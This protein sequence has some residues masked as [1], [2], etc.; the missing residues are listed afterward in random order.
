MIR[1]GDRNY[2]YWD[3]PRTGRPRSLKCPDDLATAKRRARALNGLLDEHRVLL[4]DTRPRQTT[5]LAQW[6]AVWE[7]KEKADPRPSLDDR[8]RKSRR[9]LL[10]LGEYGAQPLEDFPTRALSQVIESEVA[11]GR[12]RTAKVYRTVARSWFRRAL[13][14][15]LFPE[16]RANPADLLDAIKDPVT[17]ARLT[18]EQ[19]RA[20]RAV[21]ASVRPWLGD[22]MDL[23]LVTGQRPADL[24]ALRFADARDGYLWIKQKKTDSRVKI[25]ISLRLVAADLTVG[26][27]VAQCRNRVLSPH[28]LHHTASHSGTPAGAPLQVLN[29]ARAF[30]EA[31]TMAEIGGEHPPSFY[32][33]RSLAARLY[34]E[35]GVD[36]QV[37]LGHKHASMTEVYTDRRGAEW[38]EVTG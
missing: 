19:W 30:R 3:D 34:A 29:M 36:A 33:H 5:T 14:A 22:A 28:L 11:A 25:P 15:G 23:A 2:Y 6:V 17:R 13:G 18:L 27:V 20:V 21:A 35:Q 38:S 16:H 24:C 4:D 37:L 9:L 7:G 10:L 26:D 1:K 32:E 12:T 31:R 8:L